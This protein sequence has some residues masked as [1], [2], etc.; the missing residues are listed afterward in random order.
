MAKLNVSARIPTEYNRGKLVPLFRDIETQVN[1]HA[2]GYISAR[3]SA[4]SAAPTTGNWNLG[5]RIDN[6]TP[7]EAGTAGGKY[8]VEGWICVLAGSPGTWVE[9]RVL[10]GN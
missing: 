5:D 4:K 1:G 3:Y 9:R 2:E 7:A 10:T 6:N 8:V